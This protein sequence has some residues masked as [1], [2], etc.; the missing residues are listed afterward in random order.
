MEIIDTTFR[1]KKATI[2]YD[3]IGWK[4]SVQ[5]KRGSSRILILKA[6]AR[7]Y[8]IEPGTAIFSYCGS[9]QGRPVMVSYLDGCPRL[10]SLVGGYPVDG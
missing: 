5:N 10:K 7:A 2:E 1:L 3:A 9:I 6:V 8:C 4:S